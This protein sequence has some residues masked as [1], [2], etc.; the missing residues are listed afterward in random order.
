MILVA[1]VTMGFANGHKL[2]VKAV[3]RFKTFT[4]ENREDSPDKTAAVQSDQL[5]EDQPKTE[6]GATLTAIAQE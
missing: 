4:R 1:K 2:D 6:E 5:K 3:E